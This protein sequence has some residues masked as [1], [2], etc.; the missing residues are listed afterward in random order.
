MLFTASTESRLWEPITNYVSYGLILVLRK[1]ITVKCK[2][3]LVK[4]T[5]STQAKQIENNEI[6]QNKKGLHELGNLHTN[7]ENKNHNQKK[8][9]LR[10]YVYQHIRN[11]FIMTVLTR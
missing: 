2:F 11:K 6:A 3:R 7:I 1:K 5:D 9:K 8:N 10:L 4:Y